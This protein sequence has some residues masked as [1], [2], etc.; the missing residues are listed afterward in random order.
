[1]IPVA[2]LVIGLYLWTP[3][4]GKGVAIYAALVLAMLIAYFALRGESQNPLR[5]DE[6]NGDV[7]PNE[8][9]SNFQSAVLEISNTWMRR[10]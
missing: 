7:S 6:C 3:K 10:W 8:A 1:M 5:H 4:T 9:C 2:V